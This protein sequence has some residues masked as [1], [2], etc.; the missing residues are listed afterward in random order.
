M[1]RL[2]EPHRRPTDQ[3]EGAGPDAG[4]RE[5]PT[6]AAPAPGRDDRVALIPPERSARYRTEWESLKAGFVDEPRAAV[7]GADEL[8]GQVLD[9]LQDLF[10]RQRSALESDLHDDQSSTEDLRL[11]LS[12][13]RSF[14][15]RLLSL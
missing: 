14:F 10:R 2:D 5:T 1:S 4:Y 13:Y 8:V 3:P 6:A 15:D 11:A 12:R 7:R 9:E